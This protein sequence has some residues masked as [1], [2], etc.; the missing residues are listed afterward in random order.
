M[1]PDDGI[2]TRGGLPTEGALPPLFDEPQTLPTS[3]K[4]TQVTHGPKHHFYGYQGH[5]GN[6]PFNRS[7]THLAL[8]ET[9]FQDRYIRADDEANVLLLDLESGQ[10]KPLAT[11]RAWNFQQGTMMYWHPTNPDAELMFNDRE[12]GTN[13]LKTVLLNVQTEQR[14]EYYF[15]DTPIANSG[16][17]RRGG[18]FLG[19]NY[20]RLDRLRPVTGYKDA[21][22]WTTGENAPDDDGVWV[23]DMFSGEAELLVS[24]AQVKAQFKDEL[25]DFFEH[26]LFI[27]HTSWSRNDQR[28]FFVMRYVDGGITNAPFTCNA[29]GSDLRLAK[30]P[31][32]A[33]W[34]DD[35]HMMFEGGAVY[36][37]LTGKQVQAAPQL[38]LGEVAISQG[39]GWILGRNGE[40]ISL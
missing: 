27:N 33:D 15:A 39:G 7:G 2:S 37:I 12:P 35:T 3:W 14:R 26:E 4:V 38:S 32:H 23:V 19:L 29:D 21:Y 28:I 6:S 16:M 36:D 17:A 5:V 22:D 10:M 25:G 24:Y 18:K 11:T 34:D 20:G 13:K 8:L 9:D 30:W 1:G 31:N 40:A